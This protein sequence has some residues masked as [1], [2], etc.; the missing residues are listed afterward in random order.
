M[1]HGLTLC[2][3]PRGIRQ[4]ERC[5]FTNKEVFYGQKG[6]KKPSKKEKAG[7]TE[8]TISDT[9]E[10]SCVSNSKTKERNVYVRTC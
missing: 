9:E 10:I 5:P 4:E 2:Y 6:G 3:I 8:N 7:T 1:L